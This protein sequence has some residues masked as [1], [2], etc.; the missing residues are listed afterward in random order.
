M[1]KKIMATL[2][3]YEAYTGKEITTHSGADYYYLS[4]PHSRE[5]ASSY[6]ADHMHVAD[7]A[8]CTEEGVEVPGI[9]LIPWAETL[10]VEGIRRRLIDDLR[11]ADTNTILRVAGWL[12][13]EIFNDFSAALEL[14]VWNHT[15]SLLCGSDPVAL[16]IADDKG[17][18]DMD[19]FRCHIDTCEICRCGADKIMMM[20]GGEE[21]E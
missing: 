6:A 21:G 16:G 8:T 1:R 14:A 15:F 9:G 10:D 2:A 4:T 19:K 17:A 18:W 7:D 11:K 3:A 5:G 13:V 20:I 12:G